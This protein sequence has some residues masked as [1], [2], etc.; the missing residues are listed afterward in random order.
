MTSKDDDFPYESDDPEL[1]PPPAPP[2]KQIGSPEQEQELRILLRFLIG[3][4]VEGNDEFWRRAR[5]WQAELNKARLAGTNGSNASETEAARLRYAFIGIFFQGLDNLSGSLKSL[6]RGSGS[7]YQKFTRLINPIASSR[8]LRPVR[9]TFEHVVSKGE[10]VF[11]SWVST[12]RQ[13]EQLSRSLVR[14]QAFDDLV[15]EVLD[16]VAQK[17]EIRDLVQ[18]QSV[19]M[20]GEIVGELRERSTDVDSYL[21]TKV[22]AI[23]RRRNK[24]T[25]PPPQE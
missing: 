9:H 7:A 24:E 15:N 14:E 25:Q 17:P 22:D 8:L 23:F 4:A 13:E 11:E 19:G 10:T 20:V 21:S 3:S 2:L 5:I 18:D 1:K 16:Y 12:G 6:Q